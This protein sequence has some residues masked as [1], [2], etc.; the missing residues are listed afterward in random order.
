MIPQLH[1]AD[2]LGTMWTPGQDRGASTA[3][4]FQPVSSFKCETVAEAPSVA[5]WEARAGADNSTRL[6]P[7]V[8]C[9][10]V[11]CSS[12]LV[13]NRS[14]GNPI[15][16]RHTLR[17]GDCGWRHAEVSIASAASSGSSAEAKLNLGRFVL[18]LCPVMI[19]FDLMFYAGKRIGPKSQLGILFSHSLCFASVCSLINPFSEEMN[20]DVCNAK[21]TWK[22]SEYLLA[23]SEVFGDEET[24][25]EKRRKANPFCHRWK[26]PSPP[27]SFT[28]PVYFDFSPFYKLSPVYPGK[29]VFH[30]LLPS[31]LVMLVWKQMLC[32]VLRRTSRLTGETLPSW[33]PG[34]TCLPPHTVNH[35]THHTH[36][37]LKPRTELKSLN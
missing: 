23:S 16:G 9:L 36:A 17:F 15:T 26:E 18:I 28:R 8:L 2:A 22:P 19:S 4:C 6:Y 34:S 7:V 20:E 27:Q 12:F 13:L 30:L 1:P 5:V 21:A 35:Q 32:A 33:G 3:P 31:V 24:K 10:N 11:W 14:W 29:K 25:P 37:H